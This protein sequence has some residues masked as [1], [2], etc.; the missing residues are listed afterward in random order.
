MNNY[1]NEYLNKIDKYL[2]PMQAGERADIINEIKSEMVELETEGKLSPEQITERLGDP[3]ELAKAYLGDAI[4]KSSGFNFKKLC[5]VVAFY[6]FAGIGG[7]FVLPI[8]SV[9]GI[10][11]MLCGVIAP[12]AGLIKV[13]GYVVGIDVPWVSFQFGSNVLHPVPAFFLAVVLG[14]LLFAAGMGFWK[15]TLKYIHVVSR[16]N[17]QKEGEYFC[18]ENE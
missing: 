2:K 5:A 1:L 3:K 13:L 17:F 16:G 11:F 4:S 18:N 6:S 14:V 9:L 7:L 10:G 8:T 12:V 15:L